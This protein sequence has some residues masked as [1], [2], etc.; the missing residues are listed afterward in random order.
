MTEG[1][2]VLAID[3]TTKGFGFVVFEGP[4]Q[5]IDWGNAAAKTN[6]KAMARVADLISW[7]E[8]E[9]VV[10]EDWKGSG[11]RRRERIQQLL[12][13]I[14]GLADGRGIA[15]SQIPWQ[16]VKEAFSDLGAHTKHEIASVIALW[17]SELS[18]RLPA[19]RK[20]WMSEDQRM[21]IFDA[22]ALCMAFFSRPGYES[23][24]SLDQFVGPGSTR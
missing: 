9:V 1:T 17:F 21:A 23:N 19:P 22:A 4:A 10:L 24:D 3:P 7:Y 8:P 15:V 13:E 14:V 16:A 2:R 11:A 20:I 12:E 6:D 18:V 5:C